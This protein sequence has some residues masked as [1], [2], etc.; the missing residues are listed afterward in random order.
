MYFASVNTDQ[1]SGTGKYNRNSNQ[2]V[3]IIYKA[4]SDAIM[5]QYQEDPMNYDTLK[6][7]AVTQQHVFYQAQM[8]DT[9]RWA[10]DHLKIAEQMIGEE[11]HVET[12][13]ENLANGAI[14][15]N[16]VIEQ[17]KWSEVRL[18]WMAAEQK[19][20]IVRHEKHE[21]RVNKARYIIT[22]ITLTVFVIWTI[23]SHKQ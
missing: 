16:Q 10:D 6:Q 2:P 20:H 5:S 17:L 4:K 13:L 1:A 11:E 7:W 9:L 14:S 12:M 19:R 8:Q 18:N 3:V 22:F 21:S 15:V 23:R